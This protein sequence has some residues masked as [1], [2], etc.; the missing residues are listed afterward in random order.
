MTSFSSRFYG[1][2]TAEC[3]MDLLPFR[4]DKT[5][6]GEGT[7]GKPFRATVPSVPVTNYGTVSGEGEDN[8]AAFTAM[9]A[10]TEI[11]CFYVPAGVWEVPAG[12][13]LKKRYY[14]S[15]QLRISSVLQAP[16]YVRHEWTAAERD[17]AAP[18]N[19][20]LDSVFAGDYSRCATAVYKHVTGDDTVGTPETGYLYNPQTA[21]HFTVFLNEGG[22]SHV[23]AGGTSA[24]MSRT[25]VCAH[26]VFLQNSGAGDAVAY[27]A[28]VTVNGPDIGNTTWVGNP[29]GVILNGSVGCGANSVYVNPV[30]YDLNDDGYDVCCAGHVINMTRTND[31][32]A[33]GESW[34]GYRPQSAGTS[35]VDVMYSGTGLA[36]IGMDFTLMSCSETAIA[37]ASGHTISFAGIGASDTYPN[38]FCTNTGDVHMGVTSGRLEVLHTSRV[39]LSLGADRQ[40]YGA[41]TGTPLRTGFDVDTVTLPEL[42]ARVAALI[43]DFKTLSL[44][45]ETA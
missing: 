15:G 18:P 20:G 24:D 31:T 10:D 2:G 35:P 39:V 45:G 6:L 27:N 32:A 37:L 14:G 7:A 29:A 21:A 4:N 25:G 11:G 3:P 19:L 22:Y 34:I 30:E 41:N 5:V 1:L 16:D 33:K 8:T 9:E 38:G 12:M 44:I 36:R 40:D 26:Q 13:T 17:A 43:A 28:M 23:G 42:A